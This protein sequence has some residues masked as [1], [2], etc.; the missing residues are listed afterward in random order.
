MDQDLVRRVQ[1][2][3]EDA[4]AAL[5]VADYA[6]LFRVAHGILRDRG[7]AEDAVQAALLDIWRDIHGLRD[8]ARF[9]GWSYR[10]LVHACGREARRA[11]D[12]AD[13]SAIVSEPVAA[14]GFAAVEDRDQLE[15]GFRRISVEHRAVI[16]LRCLLEMP[17]DEVADALGVAPGTVGSR[18]HRALDAMRAALAAEARSSGTL[19]EA[20]EGAR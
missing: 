15:R 11:S 1:Q 12:W 19:G 16:V 4:F 2:G 3:D 18:L 20:P 6:R 10:I 7:A 9:G 14:D 13:V 8:L 17:M 5:A